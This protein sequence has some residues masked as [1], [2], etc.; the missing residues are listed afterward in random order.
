ML[1][2][3]VL[4]TF[5]A[6]RTVSASLFPTFP[7]AR[8]VLTAGHITTVRWIDDQERPSITMMG[9]CRIDLFV[10]YVGC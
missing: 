5:L 7:T 6:A 9:P 1:I 10:D 2:R 8:S 4:T 3:L